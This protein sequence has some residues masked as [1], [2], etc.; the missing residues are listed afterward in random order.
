VRSLVTGERST[1]TGSGYAR[2]LKLE[3]QNDSGT[4]KNVGA[5]LGID[6]VIGGEWGED[7]NEPV[8]SASFRIRRRNATMSLSPLVVASALNVDDGGFYAPLL[9]K[10]RA[11]RA[12]SATIPNGTVPG[13]GDWRGGVEGRID[14]VSWE[15]DPIVIDCSDLGAWLMDTQIKIDAVQY[16]TSPVGTAIETVIQNIVNATHS[17]K[18]T[19]AQETLYKNTTNNFAVTNW[20]QGRTK[21]LE[22]IRKVALDSTGDDVRF[23]YDAS[24]A[25][26]LTLYD[27][28]RTRSTVDATLGP[29][30][31]TKVTRLNTTITPIRNVGLLPYTDAA[32]AQHTVT[33]PANPATDQSVIDYGERYFELP[34]SDSIITSGQAQALL[35]K[36]VSD[37]NTSPLDQEIELP[38]FWPVQLYDRY[39]FLANSDH[40]DQNQT[41][42]IVGYRHEFDGLGKARTTLR[43]T[44][45]IIGAYADWRRGIKTRLAT[46]PLLIDFDWSDS[47]TER[48]YAFKGNYLVDAVWV[49]DT[50][51]A[52]NGGSGWPVNGQAPARVLT[53]S[54]FTYVAALPPQGYQ[55]WVMFEPRS[56][57][58]LAGDVR[59]SIIDA[60]PIFGNQ[61]MAQVIAADATTI[62]VQVTA[63]APAGTPTVRLA[64]V[65]GSAT[66]LSG[67]AVGVT[68]PSGQIWVFT[69]G[70]ALGGSGQAQFTA[71][72]AGNLDDSDFVELPEQGR[73]TVYLASRAR[74]TATTDTTVTVRYAVADPYPQGAG[75]V[76][77]TYQN[78]GTGGVSPASGGTIT[79][80]ATLT[81]AAGTFIDYTI[82]RPAFAAGTGRVTFTATAANRVTDSDAVDIPA[83]ERDTVQL[84]LV[85]T[86]IAATL[87]T[88][89]VQL[90]AVDPLGGTPTISVQSTGTPAITATS[91]GSNQWRLTKPAWNTAS[92]RVVFQA[93]LAGRT[94]ALAAVTVPPQT[95]ASIAGKVR[96]WPG[97]AFQPKDGTT[98]GYRKF[99][100][101]DLYSNTGGVISFN[102][103]CE[104][105]LPD[106]CTMTQFMSKT[107]RNSGSAVAT[108]SLIKVNQSTLASTTIATH[109]SSAG[110]GVEQVN[111]T[112]ISELV[113]NSTYYYFATV[114]LTPDSA[115]GLGLSE[116][117]LNSIRVTYTSPDLSVGY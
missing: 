65:T 56:I 9:E 3:V 45:K 77:S 70:P 25:Y 83:Q 112:T 109:T 20:R 106:G 7:I 12:W 92:G 32:G 14:A 81:E 59:K 75:S 74:V 84:T 21:V 62:T 64:A 76:T 58:G 94:T 15:T 16:G 18:L 48:T 51:I 37:L 98:T 113:D 49:Y 30:E 117:I 104:T 71:T 52:V 96:T 101:F 44:G 43:C 39:T 57:S 73:D 23:R 54:P 114:L 33:A 28:D 67:P 2:H 91:L 17:G 55:R 69:R 26:R 42:G 6:Y 50:L 68:A 95:S 27:P 19:T 79:P 34:S 86:Q 90:T 87:T 46:L 116:A 63:T 97:A 80:A 88:I 108:V 93:V 110:A 72:L 24:H 103:V 61:T 36:V 4:W 111:T 29:T 107:I 40:Y 11:F 47:T 100:Q 8:S 99:N 35:D 102:G 105:Y 1:L 82:T 85:A 115:G 31:Y 10:G 22:G 38:M 13:S 53:T 66:L 60:P 41:L 78:Q 5:L 89:D